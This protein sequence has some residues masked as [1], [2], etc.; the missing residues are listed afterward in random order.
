M[1]R[2]IR[3]PRPLNSDEWN[4]VVG[5][6]CLSPQQARIVELALLGQKD[7][8]IAASLALKRSTIRTHLRRIFIQLQ[9]ADRMELALRVFTAARERCK[10]KHKSRCHLK[11]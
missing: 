2:S 5:A 1:A 7:N 8:Q 6:V 9:V 3:F 4:D 10:R 11:R